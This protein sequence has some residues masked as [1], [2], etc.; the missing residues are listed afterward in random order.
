MRAQ[1]PAQT[2]ENIQ[3]PL[4]SPVVDGREHT[5]LL[6]QLTVHRPGGGGCACVTL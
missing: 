1:C 2:A 4:I 5:G 3:L 6:L